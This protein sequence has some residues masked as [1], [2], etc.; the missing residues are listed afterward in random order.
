[1][2][3]ASASAAEPIP[4]LQ[5]TPQYA[6]EFPSYLFEGLQRTPGRRLLRTRSTSWSTPMRNMVDD[7]E[8]SPKRSLSPPFEKKYADL[9]V[10]LQRKQDK[11][12]ELRQIA[13]QQK[14]KKQNE[15]V[16]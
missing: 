8:Y 13:I 11:A 10:E 15:K 2:D 16:F 5:P 14:L 12:M 4:L 3:L 6:S 7:R 1:L 9:L